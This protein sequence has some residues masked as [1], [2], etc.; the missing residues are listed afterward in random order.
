M[1]LSSMKSI[2]CNLLQTAKRAVE[3]ALEQ[4]KDAAL[5]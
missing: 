3:I 2:C 4:D 5:L 1:E